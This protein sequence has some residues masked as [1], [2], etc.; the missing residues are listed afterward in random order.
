MKLS[1]SI[2]ITSSSR[3]LL[4]D[5]FYRPRIAFEFSIVIFSHSVDGVVVFSRF[6]F[7]VFRLCTKLYGRLRVGKGHV[8]GGLMKFGNDCSLRLRP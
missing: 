2:S 6:L 1:P 3:G 8:E 5:G 4:S 7:S